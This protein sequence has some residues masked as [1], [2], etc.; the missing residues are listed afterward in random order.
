VNRSLLVPSRA[1][2][3]GSSN[4]AMQKFAGCRHKKFTP[5]KFVGEPEEPDKCIGATKRSGPTPKQNSRVFRPGHQNFSA[6]PTSNE[7]QLAFA[8]VSAPA[9]R[10]FSIARFSSSARGDSSAPFALIKNASSPP[11]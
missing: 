4:R 8:A 2:N 7:A 5:T 3:D 10:F 6:N 11:R 1:R 9:A